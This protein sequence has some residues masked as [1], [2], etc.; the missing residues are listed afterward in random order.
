VDL[1]CCALDP[2]LSKQ[3]PLTVKESAILTMPAPEEPLRF[4]GLRGC[5]VT[6]LERFGP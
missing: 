6:R 1:I 5:I 4:H 3:G 2:A